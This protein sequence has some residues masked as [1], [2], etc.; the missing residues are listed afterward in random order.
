[1]V[2]FAP[3]ESV[4]EEAAL[5]FSRKELINSVFDFSRVGLRITSAPAVIT[6]P[7]ER[8]HLEAILLWGSSFFLSFG[9]SDSG[10][11]MVVKYNETN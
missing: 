1:M 11:S 9:S 8:I 3:S 10:V 2:R 5:K 6:F 4:E 7:V